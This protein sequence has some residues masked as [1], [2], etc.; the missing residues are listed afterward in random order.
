[1]QAAT[2]MMMVAAGMAKSVITCMVTMLMP[3]LTPGCPKTPTRLMGG[4]TTPTSSLV[5]QPMAT[6]A[7]LGVMG[8][9]STPQRHMPHILMASMAVV[10]AGCRECITTLQS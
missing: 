5:T 4:T 7:S 10:L 8:R 2:D 9:I 3:L 6:R 1:M